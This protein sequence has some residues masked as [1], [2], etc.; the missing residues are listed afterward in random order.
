[1]NELFQ[2][3]NPYPLPKL[4]RLPLREQPA[5]RVSQNPDACNLVELLAAL[6]GGSQ[7]IEIA[8]ALLE[9]FGSIRRLH[10]A[11][12]IEIG[13]IHGIGQQIAIRLKAALAL[14]KKA[15][16][17]TEQERTI[18]QSPA[19]AAALVQFEMSLLEQEHL[20]VMLLDTR[21]HVIDIVEVYHG[22]VNASQV[23]VAE[24]FKP[25]IQRMATSIL[26]L[27]NHPSGDPSPSPDDVTV[28][29]AIGQAGN[30]LDIELIDHIVVGNNGRYVSLKERGLGFD[31]HVSDGRNVY[32]VSENNVIYT[33]TRAQALDDGVL[34][35]TSEMAGEAGFK[36]PTAITA[37]LYARLQ[38][39][40]IEIAHG[41]NY[42]GRLWDVL[43][44]A[45]VSARRS[46]HTDRVSFQVIVTEF[47]DCHSQKIKQNTLSL[48]CVISPGDLGEPVITIGFPR[49]F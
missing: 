21:N 20:K 19:D 49:D 48:W 36:Y 4:K 39:N 2:I 17:E 8:E 1:M 41:Q 5:Y 10:Q 9:R 37:D 31:S 43:W 23:R 14:G 16:L 33:Y 6:A 38:P 29:R 28:T 34:V 35:D 45:S 42:E 40:D 44:L 27:H 12:I 3:Q 47:D 7:Q 32:R 11:H 24:L 18:I 15:M 30:L 25:A 13:R 26:I 46:G 22:S